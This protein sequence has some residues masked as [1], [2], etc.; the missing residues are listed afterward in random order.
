MEHLR[1][2]A[3]AAGETIL[4][5]Y[6]AGAGALAHGERGPVTAADRDAHTVIIAG[7]LAWDPSIP[8][9]SEEGELPDHATRRGWPRFWLVDPLDGT[10]EFLGRNGEFTVNIALIEDGVPV[11]GVIHA[12]VLATTWVAAAGHG[13]WRHDPGA[14]PRRLLSRASEPGAPLRVVESR[15]HPSAAL[16]QWLAGRT[17]AARIRCGSS[18]K[19]CRLAEGEADVYPRLGPIMEWDVAAGDCIFRHSGASGPRPSPL[20]Y[21]QPDLRIPGFVLGLEETPDVS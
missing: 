11:L 16:E 20:R 1:R 2:L 17:V 13:A 15:S 4:G 9:I 12:P 10:K 6:E 19:F 5:H 3:E 14:A 18:L 21:D 8:V 7:L